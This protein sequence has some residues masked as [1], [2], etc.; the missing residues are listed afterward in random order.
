MNG[1]PAARAR[2][3]GPGRARAAR[4]QEGQEVRRDTLGAPRPELP[5]L[6]IGS[7][8]QAGC[9]GLVEHAL[10]GLGLESGAA[11]PGHDQPIEAGPA[12]GL[13]LADRKSTRLNSSRITIS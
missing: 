1:R 9:G 7:E 2:H 13:E 4:A 8:T 3:P 12:R 10:E 5:R 11:P 6:V